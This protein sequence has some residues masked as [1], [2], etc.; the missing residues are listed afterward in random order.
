MPDM[1]CSRRR[2]T[3]DEINGINEKNKGDS[4]QY[5]FKI[6]IFFQLHGQF[7]K[8]LLLMTPRDPNVSAVVYEH[9]NTFLMSS[10]EPLCMNRITVLAIHDPQNFHHF[11]HPQLAPFFWWFFVVQNVMFVF[12]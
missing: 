12:T 6:Q 4:V 2:K 5:H 9:I 3:L 10:Y 1:R 8:I 7:I 11:K